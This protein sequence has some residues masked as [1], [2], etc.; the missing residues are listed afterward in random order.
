M[1]KQDFVFA[2]PSPSPSLK[3][4]HLPP[5]QFPPLTL[6]GCPTSAGS[7]LAAFTMFCFAES[8]E[9]KPELLRTSHV[10]VPIG[11]GSWGQRRCSAEVHFSGIDCVGSQVGGSLRPPSS[12]SAES[13]K[14]LL[15]QLLTELSWICGESLSD[16]EPQENDQPAVHNFSP[17]PPSLP[18]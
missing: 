16:T 11:Q 7:Q 15:F 18:P 6:N 9:L 13:N 14:L 12:S 4:P 8:A 3:P 2:F 10:A 5:L 17:H 1:R